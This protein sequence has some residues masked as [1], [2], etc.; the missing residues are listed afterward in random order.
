MKAKLE[1]KEN[2]WCTALLWASLYSYCI[3][4]SADKAAKLSFPVQ[5]SLHTQLF[6]V[7]FSTACLCVSTC[8]A[9]P[10]DLL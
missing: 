1:I 10:G 6:L 4:L 7:K 5:Q 3:P 9:H 2:W 8:T